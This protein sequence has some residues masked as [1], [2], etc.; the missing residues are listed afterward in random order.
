[1]RRLLTLAVVATAISIPVSFGSL[2]VGGAAF[3]S[4]GITCSKITGNVIRGKLTIS[5]CTPIAGRSFKKAV[6]NDYLRQQGALGNLDW[7]GGAVTTVSG[8]TAVGSGDTSVCPAPAVGI[9]SSGTVTAVSSTGIGIPALGD[10]VS[11][12]VC[13]SSRGKLSLQTGKSIHL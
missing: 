10:T 6:I 8:V 11:W 7:N 4:G 1:M 9:D 12:H 5:H 2:A 3:A 13:V